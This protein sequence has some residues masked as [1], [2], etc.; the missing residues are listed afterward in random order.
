GA[1][2]TRPGLGLAA[3]GKPVCAGPAMT[4]SL[5]LAD[6][7]SFLAGGRPVRIAGEPTRTVAFTRTACLPYDPNGDYHFEQSYVSY[8]IPILVRTI[9]GQALA[10]PLSESQ[11]A[12]ARP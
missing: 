9:P 3:V 5:E 8:V 6:F 10:W 1:H 4:P 12:Q 11:C 2:H 7:G